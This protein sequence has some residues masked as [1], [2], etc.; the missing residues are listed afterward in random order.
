MEPATQN[1][2]LSAAISFDVWKFED[3]RKGKSD[4]HE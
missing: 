4:N 3:L 2:I 1:I